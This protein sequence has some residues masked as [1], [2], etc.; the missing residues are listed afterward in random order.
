M[1]KM[2]IT[3]GLKELNHLRK[4]SA[5]NRKSYELWEKFQDSVSILD[6]NKF[7]LRSRTVEFATVIR[8]ITSNK[9][10]TFSGGSRC[11]F[12]TEEP[13]QDALSTFEDVCVYN[14]YMSYTR[15]FVTNDISNLMDSTMQ[16]MGVVFYKNRPI[17][18][19]NVLVCDSVFDMAEDRRGPIMMP[20]YC[21]ISDIRSVAPL[22]GSFEELIRDSFV[23]TG[24]KQ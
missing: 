7:I 21:S 13:I 24:G 8:S 10:V 19:L 6:C 9:I 17:V 1:F 16:S 15:A 3:C 2:A 4:M 14:A 5:D 11:A 18:Y 23:V 22:S 20:D 12:M